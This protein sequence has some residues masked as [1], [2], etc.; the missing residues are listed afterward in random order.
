MIEL[1]ATNYANNK[2]VFSKMLVWTKTEM[3]WKVHLLW[4]AS[5]YGIII[6]YTVYRY[7]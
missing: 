1:E 5:A 6:L 7:Y 2:K 3:E 4:S